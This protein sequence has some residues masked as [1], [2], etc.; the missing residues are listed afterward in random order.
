[1]KPLR[2]FFF[3]AFVSGFL[4]AL[5][6][7]LAV[8]LMLKGM[9]SLGALLRPLTF[10]HPPGM[11]TDAAEGVLAVLV[12]LIIC[13]ILGA[14]ILTRP[15]RVIREHLERAFLAKIPG[16]TVVRGL[17]QQIAGQ[18]RDDEWKPALAD[19]GAS[20]VL[21]LIIEEVDEDRY[22][23][24]IP[25]A[26]SPFSGPL[27]I[28]PKTRVHPLNVSP[29]QVFQTVSRWG[30]GMKDLVAAQTRSD[31]DIETLAEG[32]TPKKAA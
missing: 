25:S 31:M 7:Y 28:L 10:L 8:L 23:I 16:Y 13:F 15:G 32:S 22:A 11:S 24:F 17:T 21:A 26:P 19:L 4:L 6:V 2:D 27:H 5:P 12:S 20:T 3:K 30:S 18:G 1:M 9:K 29:G 14:L